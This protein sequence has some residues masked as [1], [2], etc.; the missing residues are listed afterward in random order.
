MKS[1][2]G[3]IYCRQNNNYLKKEIRKKLRV[4]FGGHGQKSEESPLR[5]D[6][7]DDVG[8]YLVKID[9]NKVRT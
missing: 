7:D 4:F 1:S 6:N 3:I 9:K 5:V 2:L 8:N